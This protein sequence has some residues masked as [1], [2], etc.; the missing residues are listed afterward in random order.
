MDV[1]QKLAGFYKIITDEAMQKKTEMFNSVK[2]KIEKE[3]GETLRKTYYVALQKISSEKFELDQKI[4]NQVVNELST[5]RKKIFAKRNQLKDKL[6][7][8]V[9]KKLRD[10]TGTNEYKGFIAKELQSIDYKNPIIEF[11]MTDK[12]LTEH[13][14]KKFAFE[15]FIGKED[16]VGGYKIY[17]NNSKIVIDKSFKTRLTKFYDEFNKF[18]LPNI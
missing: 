17:L 6:F 12:N 5:S 15:F 13:I 11:S 9:E 14:Q 4:N 8:E 18:K 1:Q 7:L 2:D 10:F 16:F 3:I